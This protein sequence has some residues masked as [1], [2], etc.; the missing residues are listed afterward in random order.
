VTQ[1]GLAGAQRGERDPPIGL[2]GVTSSRWH[3]SEKYRH[4]TDFQDLFQVASGY[5]EG[6][7][8]V[9]WVTAGLCYPEILLQTKVVDLLAS[10]LASADVQPDALGTT[11]G[12]RGGMQKSSC[13][14]IKCLQGRTSAR[15]KQETTPKRTMRD[16]DRSCKELVFM[17][18]Y[19][20]VCMRI[21]TN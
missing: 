7:R 11:L 4:G 6:G 17:C 18:A 3:P 12:W 13:A 20:W 16:S 9:P 14:A 1:E 19:V 8:Q 15:P 2:R 10:I 21:T 5:R